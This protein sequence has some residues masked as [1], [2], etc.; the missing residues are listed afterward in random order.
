MVSCLRQRGGC[1]DPL[2]GLV[3]VVEW[4]LPARAPRLSSSLPTRLP[5]GSVRGLAGLR[6]RAFACKPVHDSCRGRDRLQK[7]LWALTAAV[8]ADLP[9]QRNERR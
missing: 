8:G 1:H 9:N 6:G 7:A 2:S 5:K 3:T 4:R